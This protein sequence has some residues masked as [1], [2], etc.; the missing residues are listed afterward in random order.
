QEG[1]AA[2][3][4]RF[5]TVPEIADLLQMK[6]ERVYEAVRLG[7]VPA[8]HIGRQIRIEEKAFVEWVRDGGQTHAAG[9]RHQA[10]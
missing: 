5:F 9:W 6:R 2:T 4:L 10:S 7:L 8:V 1:P 3:A